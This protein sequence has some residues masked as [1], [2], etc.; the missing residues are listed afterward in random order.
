MI[1]LFSRKVIHF[2]RQTISWLKNEYYDSVG[3][4][5]KL[6]SIPNGKNHLASGR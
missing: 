2:L 4:S 1:V 3:K 5:A 6:Q